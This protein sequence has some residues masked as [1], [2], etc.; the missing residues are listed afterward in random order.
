M[1]A[2]EAS[3][4]VDRG[5]LR[6]LTA[7]SVDDGK[8]TLIGRL[9]YDTK[10]ILAD[11]LAAIER[12]S[13]RR[14]QTL[15]LSLLTDGLVAEREQGITI[16]VAYRYFATAVR[17]FIIADAPGHTQYTRNMVTAASTAQLAI[18]LVDARHGVVTQTRRHAVLAHLVGIPHLV[19]AVNK[20]DLVDYR[21][22][23]FASI[24]DEFL[25][26]AARSGISD[27][28][29]VPI[30]ALEGDMVVE[31]GGNLP[32]YEGPTLLQILETA[33]V[34]NALVDAPFRFP[35]QYVA[36]PNGINRRGY[37]GRI[38][39]GSIAV[40][41]EVCLLPTGLCTRVSAIRTFHGDHA[42]AGLH[43]AITLELGDEID[44]SRGDMLV[45]AAKPPAISRMLE[46]SLCWL[47]AA[48]LDTN[49]KYVLR[50]TT[51]EVRARVDRI[52]HLWNVASQ[53]CEPAPPTLRMNDIGRVALSLAQPVFAD[54]Y[55][56]NQVT[57]SF[58]VIDEV[59]NNT[60]AAGLIE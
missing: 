37:M 49:R 58:I 46:A 24:V 32:W 12:T 5:V 21:P 36:R 34:S 10:A 25:D 16:D 59:T 11:Q 9:L 22:D 2:I 53:Q 3:E 13:Q 42:S 33:D 52:D 54:R 45:S 14:G 4:L 50:H 15:D 44:V 39:S 1:A 51:R 41:D 56:D 30:S 17:K 31:R 40:G 35:V 55:A 20:M 29:F 57:G 6:F 48:P 47:D 23:A 18:L 43:S 27:V 19:V 28:R 38:E 60:V 7:G 26:F 8:S